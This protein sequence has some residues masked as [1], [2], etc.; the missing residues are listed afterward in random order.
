MAKTNPVAEAYRRVDEDEVDEAAKRYIDDMATRE[1]APKR[2]PA[3][4]D[5]MRKRQAEDERE[6][7]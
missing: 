3:F 2:N 6:Q 7:G 5:V 1:I 4:D